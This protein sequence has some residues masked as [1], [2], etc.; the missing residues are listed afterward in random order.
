MTAHRGRTR[1]VAADIGGTHVSTAV[2]DTDLQIHREQRF[3]LDAD[4]PAAELLD[5]IGEAVRCQG[6]PFDRV[7][8]AVPGPFD[9]R[10]GIGDFRGVAKFGALQGVNMRAELACRWRCAPESVRFVNDAEAFGLGEWAAG[11]AGGVERAVVLTLGTGIGSAFIEDGRCV[12]SGPR[13]PPE[14]DMHRV[15]VDGDPLEERVSRRA[16]MRVYSELSGR[17]ADVA[18]VAARARA[19][20]TA[21]VET[22]NAGMSVL[23]RAVAPWLSR[24]GAERLVI[25]GSMAASYDLLFPP[26]REELT[27]S[28]E[29]P[30]SLA[31]GILPGQRASLLGAAVASWSVD[32]GAP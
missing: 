30:P 9:Y 5:R 20:E 4:A 6:G 27:A 31:V 21:A 18:E 16:L 22:L 28:M 14:G 8:L 7:A 2:V 26:L 10:R 25:G 13:V 19:G 15:T 12:G 1:T 17:T 23:G 32:G 29:R 3:A 24:F 11:S